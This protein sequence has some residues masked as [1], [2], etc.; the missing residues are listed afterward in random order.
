MVDAVEMADGEVV[1]TD[2]D[3]PSGSDRIA[4]ALYDTITAF[5]KLSKPAAYLL[6]PYLLWVS[7]ATYLNAAFWLLNR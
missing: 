5:A 7:Y 6:I 2:P 1:M 4:A 3:L